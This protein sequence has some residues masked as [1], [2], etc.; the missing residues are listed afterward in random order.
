MAEYPPLRPATLLRRMDRLGIERAVVLA[1]ENPEEV[2]WYLPSTEVLRVCRRHPDRLVPFCATDPRHGPPEGFDP[3]PILREY[4]EQGCRGFGEYLA[5]LD[6]DDP[7]SLRIYEACRELNLPVLLHFDSYINRD[8]PGFPR[9]ARVL[10]MFSG[11][12]VRGTRAG[13]VGAN[14]SGRDTGAGLS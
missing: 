12:H 4:V 8:S 1:V 3:L 14:I 5:G 2:H 10:R 11:S 6:V 13:V 9:F 7:R